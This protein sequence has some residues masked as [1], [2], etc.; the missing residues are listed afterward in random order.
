MVA[1][2]RVEAKEVRFWIF[3]KVELIGFADGLDTE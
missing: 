1:W 3:F 2:T